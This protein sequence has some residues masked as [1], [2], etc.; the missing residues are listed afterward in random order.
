MNKIEIAFNNLT[1]ALE[2]F[3]EVYSSQVSSNMVTN[4]WSVKD[5]LCHITY[6]H[7]YYADNLNAEAKGEKYLFP[8]IKYSILSQKGFEL[9]RPY[10]SEELFKMIDNSHLKIRDSIFVGKVSEMTYREGSK[11][12]PI[13]E[14]LHI[15]EG[16]IRG[17]TKDIRLRKKSISE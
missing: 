16:H 11:P 14:F 3:K 6:W 13:I 17:H 2:K 5:I 8:K 9:L 10:S 12:Y 4:E 1:S 15:V 7:N